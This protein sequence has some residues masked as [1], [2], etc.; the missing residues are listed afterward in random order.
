MCT[1]LVKKFPANPAAALPPSH[2]WLQRRSLQQQA[3]EELLHLPEAAT[4]IRLLLRLYEV[5]LVLRK[6]LV[7]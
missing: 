7:V 1:E 3:S 2:R 6:D 4:T 5:G